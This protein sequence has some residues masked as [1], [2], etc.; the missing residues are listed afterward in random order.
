MVIKLLA[1]AL[2]QHGSPFSD[3]V[4]IKNTIGVQT[5]VIKAARH[6]LKRLGLDFDKHFPDADRHRNSAPPRLTSRCIRSFHGQGWHHSGGE[7]AVLIC[8][9]P[10]HKCNCIAAVGCACNKPDMPWSWSRLVTW[11]GSGLVVQ[12]FSSGLHAALAEHLV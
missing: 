7:L 4:A 9:M 5:T 11:I 1:V 12:V 10:R 6:F 3:S 8:S 2:Q